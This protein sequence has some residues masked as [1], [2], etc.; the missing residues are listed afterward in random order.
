LLNYVEMCQEQA[1]RYSFEVPNTTHLYA[2]RLAAYCANVDYHFRNSLFKCTE[3]KLLQPFPLSIWKSALDLR[4]RTHLLHLYIS[5]LRGLFRSGS[6]IPAA[7]STHRSALY[8]SL[9]KDHHYPL[10]PF[11]PHWDEVY[12]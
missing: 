3:V 11:T 9:L 8:V 5:R 7:I 10:P 1:A 2:F 12:C 4:S 6:S